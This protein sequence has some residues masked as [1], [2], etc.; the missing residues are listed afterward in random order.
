MTLSLLD[1]FAF[2]CLLQGFWAMILVLVIIKAL[3]KE[4]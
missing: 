4:G 1:I 3:K 2:S